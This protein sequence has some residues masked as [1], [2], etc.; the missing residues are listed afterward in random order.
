M[1]AC[2]AGIGSGFNAKS[3]IFISENREL[4]QSVMWTTAA[5]V[6]LQSLVMGG[7]G[8]VGSRIGNRGVGSD[9]RAVLDASR[10]IVQ[11]A[12]DCGIST[13]ETARLIKDTLDRNLKDTK[14]SLKG[15]TS[16]FSMAE[17]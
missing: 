6:A 4:D 11:A 9:V 7:A 12:E 1:A 5:V 17:P 13:S 3:K 15:S 14:F 10:D 2:T 8:H 16:T